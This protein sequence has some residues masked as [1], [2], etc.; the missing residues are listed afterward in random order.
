AILPSGSARASLRSSARASYG[1]QQFPMWHGLSHRQLKYL[2]MVA[3][4]LRRDVKFRERSELVCKMCGLAHLRN[5]GFLA[6]TKCVRAH[7]GLP[8]IVKASR[9]KQVRGG[10]HD[11]LAMAAFVAEKC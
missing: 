9:R 1:W 10:R 6:G 5:A 3:E 11:D 8:L 7:H 4:I 2:N